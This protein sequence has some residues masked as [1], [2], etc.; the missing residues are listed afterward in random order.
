VTEYG[1]WRVEGGVLRPPSGSPRDGGAD[2]EPGG[3]LLQA[4]LEQS[5]L[6][7]FVLHVVV[8]DVFA[9]LD[10]RGIDRLLHGLAEGDVTP[11][12]WRVVVLVQR[13]IGAVDVR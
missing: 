2:V 3:V 11:L 13:W 8:A 6:Q 9:E 10:V 1:S 5:C 4:A 7:C 12:L